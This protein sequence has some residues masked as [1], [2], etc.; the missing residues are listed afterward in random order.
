MKFL[1]NSK[2]KDITK[3]EVTLTDWKNVAPGKKGICKLF[4]GIEP[5]LMVLQE[6]RNSFD[7]LRW[8]NT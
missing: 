3:S 1:W 7:K 8:N 6:K 5:L 4:P 2:K